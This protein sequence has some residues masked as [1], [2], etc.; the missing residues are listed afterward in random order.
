[1]ARDL[2]EL[3]FKSLR[4]LCKTGLET[5]SR[6]FGSAYAIRT[7]GSRQVGRW[8]TEENFLPPGI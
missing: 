6:L 8:V 1:M 4:D 7:L 5:V 3:V 2:T